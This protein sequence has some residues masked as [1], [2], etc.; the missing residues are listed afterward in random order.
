MK[1]HITPSTGQPNVCTATVRACPVGG[2]SEHYA[3][4]EEAQA[5]YEQ[6]RKDDLVAPP[7]RRT[8]VQVRFCGSC[9]QRKKMAWVDNKL[10]W[11]FCQECAERKGLVP[12][13]SPPPVDPAPALQEQREK[14]QRESSVLFDKFAANGKAKG[15]VLK[16]APG[17]DFDEV[18]KEMKALDEEG[19][20][21]SKEQGRIDD[22]L[23]KVM[24]EEARR[25]A[26]GKSREGVPSRGSAL[27]LIHHNSRDRIAEAVNGPGARGGDEMHY[28]MNAGHL[29]PSN[30]SEGS[31]A[32]YFEEGSNSLVILA[33]AD[34]KR[35]RAVSSAGEF[36]GEPAKVLG[37]R[38]TQVKQR[39]SGSD[40]KTYGLRVLGYVSAEGDL[41][42]WVPHKNISFFVY[43]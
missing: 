24:A 32:Q 5:A 17:R 29:N 31:G 12:R 21:L 3:T 10:G 20:A 19:T 27:A 30:R 26:N 40:A 28:T 14:L 13:L 38:V 39:A 16:S 42:G 34:G 22:E 23:R 41:Y 43:K 25:E 11:R 33:E 8:T 35:V 9:K 4:R 1:Y 6:K 37:K 7:V 36:Y 18:L 2:E 15:A